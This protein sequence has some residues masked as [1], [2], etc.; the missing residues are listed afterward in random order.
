MTANTN[1]EQTIKNLE[2]EILRLDAED[3]SDVFDYESQHKITMEI[4]R[5]C[6]LRNKLLKDELRSA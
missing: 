6:K 4:V 1:I 5:L 2:L 3:S